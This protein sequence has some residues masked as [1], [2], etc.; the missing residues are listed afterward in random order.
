M[1]ER[2]RIVFS[3]HPAEWVDRNMVDTL[4][5]MNV[6]LSVYDWREGYD[7]YSPEW[8]S[9]QRKRMN[10]GLLKFV[11]DRSRKAPVDLLITYFWR[12]HTDGKVI[13][14]IRDMGVRCVNFGCN[15][16]HQFH[17]VKPL[18]GHYDYHWVTERDAVKLF[19]DAGGAAVRVQMGANPKYYFPVDTAKIYDMSFTGS[20]YGERSDVFDKVA[21][22]G[23]AFHVFGFRWGS[24]RSFHR[25][26]G[27]QLIPWRVL[28]KYEG[29]GLE[30]GREEL[31]RQVLETEH[32][33]RRLGGIGFE[34]WPAH[35]PEFLPLLHGPIPFKDMV[36][37]FSESRISMNFSACGNPS[38]MRKG[39]LV[40]VK[41]R[42]FEAPMSGAVLFTEYQD[43]LK[44]F[45]E[46]DK[47]IVCYHD[48]PDLI[49]KAKR[50]LAEPD[51]AARIGA[52]ARARSLRDHTWQNRFQ[53]L[54]S[55][56]KLRA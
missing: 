11:E 51:E 21:R 22:A 1:P 26:I 34:K 32:L 12:H 55:K 53:E 49:E 46:I 3:S 19:T 42:D 52:A 6:D 31:I 17:L 18:I 27:E 24:K 38:D 4:R 41:L 30:A 47:E 25:I 20:C 40:Q 56:L 5:E 14:K 8:Q 36:R 29:A 35:H 45:Y 44:E 16:L 39:R 37:L 43:E 54:F 33:V 15:N 48:V 23:I 50:L 9:S 10:Q 13:D 28:Y 7:F 2:L